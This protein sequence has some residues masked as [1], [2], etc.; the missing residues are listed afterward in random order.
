MIMQGTFQN[1]PSDFIF[2]LVVISLRSLLII[3][4]TVFLFV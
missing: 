2:M 4:Y 3:K 1:F